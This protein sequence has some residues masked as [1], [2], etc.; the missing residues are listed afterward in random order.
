MVAG[1]F[2]DNI[3]FK[4]NVKLQKYLINKKNNIAEKRL[5]KILVLI[6]N[7]TL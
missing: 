5:N 6:A 4:N 1:L 7:F 3:F 2:N